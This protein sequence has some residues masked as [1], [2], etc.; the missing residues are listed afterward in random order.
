[1]GDVASAIWQRQGAPISCEA[2]QAW[3]EHGRLG[4]GDGKTTNHL[5]NVSHFTEL[6]QLC[7]TIASIAREMQSRCNYGAG[8]VQQHYRDVPGGRARPAPLLY[9]YGPRGSEPK[10]RLRPPT[11]TGD[12]RMPRK[13]IA[14]SYEAAVERAEKTAMLRALLGGTGR[15]PV[16]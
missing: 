12:G 6:C 13:A 2:G 11:R 3:R 10:K 14:S 9:R 16:R 4:P 7:N 8:W 1:M 15:H 5:V